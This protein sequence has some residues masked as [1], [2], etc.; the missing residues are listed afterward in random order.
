M[1]ILARLVTRRRWWVLGLGVAFLPVAGVLGGS[2]EQRLSSGGLN[3]PASESARAAELLHER[4]AAGTPNVVLLVTARSGTVDDGPVAAAGMEV[5]RRLA[6]EK[7]LSN[8][9]SYWNLGRAAPLRSSDGHQALVLG[10]APGDED[11]VRRATEGLSARYAGAH[12]PITVG[13]GGTGEVFN[14]IEIQAEK[15][16]KQAELLTFPVTVVLLMFVFGS[17]VAAALPLAVGAL[18]VVGTFC[19]LRLVTVFTDVSIFALNL[20]TAMGLGLAI[21]YSLFVVSRYREELRHGYEPTQAVTRCLHTAGRTVAF[22]ALTVAVSLAALVVFPLPFLRSFAFAGVGVVLLAAAGAVVVLPALLAV[23][24]RRIDTLTLWHRTAKPVEAGFWYRRARAVM[25]RPIPVVIVVTGVLVALGVPFAGLELGLSDDRVLPSGA[26]VRQVGDDIRRHFPS[27]EAGAL[28]VVAPDADATAEAGHV[29]RYAA[30]VSAL[31]GVARVDAATGYYGGGA[32]ISPPNQLS[33]RFAGT[34]SGT[35]LSVVPAVE[36]LSPAGEQLVKTLRRTPAPFDVLVTGDSAR[37]V[38]GKATLAGHLPLA[39][40]I[41]VGVTFALL[42]LMVGSLL[43]PA[44]ALLLNVLSLSATFGS[45]V[46][47]FQDGHLA[48]A[49]H[50]TPTG[51]ISIVTP[52]LLFCI[53]FGLSMDYEVFLLSR[54]KEEYDL[55][56]DNDDAVALGLER[57]GRIVTAAALLLAL[58][59]VAFATAEVTVVKIFGVGLALAVLVDAFLIRAT[60]VPA[61]MRLAGRANW[62]APRPLRRFHLRWGIFE[63]EPPELL[64]RVEAAARAQT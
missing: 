36:P 47:V 33:V 12:G 38:D 13:V 42:F 2:V 1:R 17:A 28:A 53:A 58:V 34:G 57:T 10:R 32:V 48:G 52:V 6:A 29:D 4:F 40:G 64:D 5:T 14:Q 23:L 63:D 50:F 18:A 54:I 24:G 43:V 39:L 62:W 35:W 60:L 26:P 61:L 31:P 46:W 8:V 21:D 30:A 22:S 11:D 20:T 15:D 25:G 49:L 59:F 44:K 16:L 27:R 7:G 45:L 37:L 56:A 9:V 51:T 41:V 55:G 19:V 3:D